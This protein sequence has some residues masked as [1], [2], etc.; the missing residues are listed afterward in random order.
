M[1]VCVFSPCTQLFSDEILICVYEKPELQIK[2]KTTSMELKHKCNKKDAI[3]SHF[4]HH[5]PLNAPLKV[6]LCANKM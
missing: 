3:T 4:A 1:C 2:P 6:S 5:P